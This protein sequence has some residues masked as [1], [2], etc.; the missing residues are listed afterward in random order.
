MHEFLFKLASTFYVISQ[1]TEQ[2][3]DFPAILHKYDLSGF[4]RPPEPG[5]V[6]IPNYSSKLYTQYINPILDKAGTQG[7]VTIQM[8]INPNLSTTIK[9]TGDPTAKMIETELQRTLGKKIEN[10]LLNEKNIIPPQKPLRIGGPTGWIIN[11]G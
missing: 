9:V 3:S 7:K 6:P 2:A 11:Y 10:I 4:M 1:Y 8:W 5:S